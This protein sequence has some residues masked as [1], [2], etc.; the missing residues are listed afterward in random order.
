MTSDLSPDLPIGAHLA[1]LRRQRG[2]TGQDLGLRAQMS[3]AK[4]SRIET[5]VVVAD[6]AD[7]GRLARALGLS[8]A[9]AQELVD[10]AEQAQHHASEWRTIPVGVAERQREVAALENS[11]REFRVFQPTV[12]FGLLQTS[13]YARAI[14][15]KFQSVPASSRMAG[16]TADI[17]EAVTARVRRHEVL[18]EPGRRFHFLMSEAVLDNR[19][20]RPHEMVAQIERLREAAAEEN[21]SLRIIPAGARWSIPPYHGFELMDDRCIL[22]DLFSGSLMSRERGAIRM[23]RQVFDAL[24]QQGTQDIDPILDR[25]LDLYL[26]LTRRPRART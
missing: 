24:E 25:Y 13:E 3:Q 11:T 15:S 4:V 8:D 5:G 19:L 23:Y 18:A 22:V 26:D 21:T 2:L 9:E 20:C 16:S 7:V 1:R 6:P 14:L 12:V 10:R 17:A